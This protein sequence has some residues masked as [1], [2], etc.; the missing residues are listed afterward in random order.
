MLTNVYLDFIKNT[1]LSEGIHVADTANKIA[2]FN[3][4]ITRDQYSA[5]AWIIAQEVLKR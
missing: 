1:I 5:A 3:G 2:L 4:D